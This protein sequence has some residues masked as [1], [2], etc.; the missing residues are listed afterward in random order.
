MVNSVCWS[1]QLKINFHEQMTQ[2]FDTKKYS[3]LQEA[4]KMLGKTMIAMDQ[5]RTY[6]STV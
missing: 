2:T 6:S 4:Y 1:F 5:V 3:K